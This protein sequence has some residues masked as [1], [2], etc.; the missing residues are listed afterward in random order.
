MLTLTSLL[1]SCI[2]IKCCNRYNSE[3]AQSHSVHK[4]Y[5]DVHSLY[6]F[7][8]SCEAKPKYSYSAKVDI[9]MIIS[10]WL[11]AWNETS[12]SP[13]SHVISFRNIL[14]DFIDH[15]PKRL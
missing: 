14:A 4:F 8:I 10:L 5:V 1:D 3:V 11:Y 12:L 7:N 13:F 15:Y 2:T 9:N 6:K